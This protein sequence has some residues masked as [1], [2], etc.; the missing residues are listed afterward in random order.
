M[1]TIADNIEAHRRL[2]ELADYAATDS[3]MLGSI[4][5]PV[6]GVRLLARN[7]REE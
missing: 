1:T 6:S 4:V 3:V 2:I 5:L 7:S